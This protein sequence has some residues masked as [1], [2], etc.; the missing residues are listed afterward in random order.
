ML[1][2]VETRQRDAGSERKQKVAYM[3]YMIYRTGGDKVSPS[4]KPRETKNSGRERQ[5][6]RVVGWEV[7]R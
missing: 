3:C 7:V 4:M 5:I 6:V 1:N 2:L